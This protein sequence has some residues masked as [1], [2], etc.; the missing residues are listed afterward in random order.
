MEMI[1]KKIPC[2]VCAASG[3]VMFLIEDNIEHNPIGD[4]PVCG[5]ECELEIYVEDTKDINVVIN[6]YGEQLRKFW[7]VGEMIC[8]Q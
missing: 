4:C 7:Q 2:P 5:G 8:P 6:N 1:Q 3:K